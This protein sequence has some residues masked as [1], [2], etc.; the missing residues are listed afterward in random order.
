MPFQ[1][2]QNAVMFVLQLLGF[3]S[4][5]A[6]LFTVVLSENMHR[7][8]VF[9]NFL[10]AHLL[11]TSVTIFT[12]VVEYL[13]FTE[14]E[15]TLGVA[16]MLDTLIDSV[17]FIA[18]TA[19]LNLVIHLWF[20]MRAAF[21]CV[22]ARITKL[23]T[24]MLLITPY[25]MGI[26]PLCLL[27][28][29]NETRSNFLL[30]AMA[31]L[32]LSLVILMCLWDIL[33]VVTFCSYRRIFRRVHMVNIMTISLLMRLSVFCLFRLL[34][35]VIFMTWI[36]LLDRDPNSNGTLIMEDTTNIGESLHPLV[37]FLLLGLQRDV[38]QVW[39]PCIHFGAP[40]TCT[41]G[42]NW[43]LDK[44]VR[45][46]IH[47]DVPPPESLPDIQDMLNKRHSGTLM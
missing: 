14:T 38:L 26:V 46:A 18:L 7:H 4:L 34:Y 33:L 20:E 31:Y 6:L 11:Y 29:V 15:K 25:F 9:F 8:T 5:S 13:A 36:A 23:R 22:N 40:Q 16:T 35:T 41:T 21:R 42:S 19:T 43:A 10:W 47:E 3:V 30:K 32:Q 39:F 27:F 2:I 17:R 12:D 44:E 37:A 24:F 28:D 45:L 1:G